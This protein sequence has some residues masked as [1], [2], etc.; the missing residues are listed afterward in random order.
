M[1][2]PKTFITRHSVIQRS[3]RPNYS[4][5]AGCYSPIQVLCLCWP[6][7]LDTPC[8]WNYYTCHLSSGRDDLRLSCLL[9]QTLIPLESIA[10]LT[11]AILLRVQ[12]S[13][14]LLY[15][16]SPSQLP[17]WLLFCVTRVTLSRQTDL[18]ALPICLCSCDAP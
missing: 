9:T 6:P 8:T 7:R 15:T 12:P 4:A 2:G 10:N 5:H 17:D 18:G 13:P 11:D 1:H 16:V 14:M 3:P